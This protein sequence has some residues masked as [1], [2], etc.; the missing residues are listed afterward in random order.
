MNQAILIQTRD[1]EEVFGEAPFK[2]EKLLSLIGK[3]YPGT[4]E[5]HSGVWENYTLGQHTLMVMRQFEKYFADK[6]LPAGMDRNKFRLFLALHDIGKPEAIDH[7]GKHLQHGYTIQH[8]QAL[9][10]RLGID[11]KHTDAAIVLASG[12]PL[13]AY[14]RDRLSVTE[15]KQTLEAMAV[16]AN[17]P[18]HEFF[19]L[20]CLYYKTDAGSYTVNAGGIKSLDHLFLFDEPHHTL[21]FAPHIQ[22]KIDRLGL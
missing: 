9:Y 13:G 16:R 5:H 12:D 7:G 8:I 17:L 20:L 21:N 10:A 22:E 1:L 14:L 15:T 4:Y 2:P 18:L 11:K 3:Q 19:E 6:V